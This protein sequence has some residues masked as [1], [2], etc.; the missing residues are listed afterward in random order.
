M[1]IIYILFIKF[2][3][4]ASSYQCL[5]TYIISAIHH[6][7]DTGLRTSDSLN[8]LLLFELLELTPSDPSNSPLSCFSSEYLLYLV[9]GREISQAMGLFQTIENA[10]KT[11][12]EDLDLSCDNM[13]HD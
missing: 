7:W 5:S 10:K 8:P 6:L 4:A 1:E 9:K 11:S 3:H 2:S 12:E 13:Y